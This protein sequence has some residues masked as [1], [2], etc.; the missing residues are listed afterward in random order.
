MSMNIHSRKVKYLLLFSLAIS[1]GIQLH[2][3]ISIV[4]TVN[5]VVPVLMELAQVASTHQS[6]FQ[7]SK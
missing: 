5:E 2:L 6:Q 1:V 4:V 7:T 3:A